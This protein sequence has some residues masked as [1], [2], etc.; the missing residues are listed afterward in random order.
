VFLRDLM[1][2]HIALENAT[3]GEAWE[4]ASARV[5][6]EP[7]A[8]F[9]YGFFRLVLP[10]VAFLAVALVLVIPI[11]V[12]TIGFAAMIAGLTAAVVNTA[13]AAKVLL[14]MIEVVVTLLGLGI[15]LFVGL[16]VGGPVATAIRNYTLVFYG[17]RYQ[18][19][20]NLLYPPAPPQPA[21]GMAGAPI[22]V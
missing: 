20:G 21:P 13:G 19:L 11:A 2:P 7:G 22:G 9:L 10:I 5:G 3:V 6:A 14:V 8:F 1:L 15:S 4:S 16:F 12:I 18:L 17:S